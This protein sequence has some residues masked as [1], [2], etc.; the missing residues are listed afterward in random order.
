SS[1]RRHT[2]SK[3]DWSSDVC[4]SDLTV[5]SIPLTSKYSSKLSTCRPK[6]FLSTVTSNLFKWLSCPITSVANKISPAHVPYIGKS[7]F[8]KASVK[9]Y[10]SIN[11]LIV[12]DS[13]PGNTSPSKPL[14]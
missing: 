2:S 6:E 1:R 10:K 5:S 8:L 14:N 12:V 9:P 13:P 3:R 4:S 7:L 11:L